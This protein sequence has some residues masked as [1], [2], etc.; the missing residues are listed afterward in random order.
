MTC[1][2]CLCL[3]TV[4]RY[5]TRW[6]ERQGVFTVT[7]LDESESAKTDAPKSQHYVVFYPLATVC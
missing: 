6:P 5:E 4:G 3:T 1:T 2:R 7:L